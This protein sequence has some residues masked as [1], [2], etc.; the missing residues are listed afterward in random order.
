MNHGASATSL[1]L[2]VFTVIVIVGG[3]LSSIGLLYL[4][5]AATP[6]LWKPWP[7]LLTLAVSAGFAA[8]GLWG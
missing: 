4:I 2:T 6:D 3:T 8:V 7:W 1:D 5:H